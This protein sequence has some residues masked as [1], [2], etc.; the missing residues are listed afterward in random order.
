MGIGG[1]L[2]LT[3]KW[4]LKYENVDHFVRILIIPGV[5]LSYFMAH[6]VV[7]YLG[8]SGSLGLTR[9]ITGVVPIVGLSAVFAFQPLFQSI[10]LKAIPYG[11]IIVFSIWSI[12]LPSTTDKFPVKLGV[13]EVV[14]KEA[15]DYML[16]KKLQD[17]FVVYYNP[18]MSF[19][20]DLD[21][22]D[23]TVSK[24][25]V[26]DKSIPEKDLPAGTIV[27]WDAHFGPNEG[28][29][30][31][32]KLTNNSQFELIKSFDPQYPFTVLGDHQYQVYLF[33]RL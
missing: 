3:L 19:F 24:E 33:K 26:F 25:Q 5:V 15:A 27:V 28:G 10:K 7:W 13:E 29:L 30:P 23:K 17:S 14:L 32:E 1:L 18:I 6:T 9:I 31:L 20:L 4:L 22:Y 2:V 16:D 11:L 12:L 21:P 8:I